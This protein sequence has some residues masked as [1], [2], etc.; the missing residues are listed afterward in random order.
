MYL[1]T[2]VLI[3]QT[4]LLLEPRQT[5]RQ[6]NTRLVYFTHAGVDNKEAVIGDGTSTQM[7]KKRVTFDVA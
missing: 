1:P 5:D 7:I 2:L 6:T 4:V 3:A